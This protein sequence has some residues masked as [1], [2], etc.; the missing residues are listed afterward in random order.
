MIVEVESVENNYYNGIDREFISIV[1][2]PAKYGELRTYIDTTTTANTIE[3]EKTPQTDTLS[4][5]KSARPQDLKVKLTIEMN[6]TK[7]N[8]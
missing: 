8:Y 5:T 6:P 1:C 4:I 7:L 2:S 3:E